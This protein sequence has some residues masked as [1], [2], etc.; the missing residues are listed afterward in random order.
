LSNPN[1]EPQEPRTRRDALADL[2]ARVEAAIDEVRPKIRRALEELDAKVDAA[3]ADIR[4]KAKSAM[5][6]VQP[7]VD[8]FVA[9]VQP[10]L[11][12]LLQRLQA[13]IDELRRDLDA[14]ASRSPREDTEAAAG[15]LTAGDVPVAET[16]PTPPDESGTR[17]PNA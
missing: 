7:K 6:D 13:K 5:R 2:Q 4:P 12:S 3:V 11:D 10:R 14:R 1:A 8:Q 15:Q 9:D 17:P 16:P